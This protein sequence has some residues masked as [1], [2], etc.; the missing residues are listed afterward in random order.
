MLPEWH[1]SPFELSCAYT[2]DPTGFYVGE[3]KLLNGEIIS[4]INCIYKYLG[5]STF[6]S[7][8]LVKAEDRAKGCGRQTWDTAWKSLDSNVSFGLD[9][10]TDMVPKHKT[11]G[12]RSVWNTL[13]VLL[14][15]ETITK[16]NAGVSDSTV[17][18]KPINTIDATKV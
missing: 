15:L 11:L 10:V 14:A 8:F 17:S 13:V 5:H 1:V 9:A 12:F 3:L 18:I 6:I 16:K 7:T 4:V 2:L